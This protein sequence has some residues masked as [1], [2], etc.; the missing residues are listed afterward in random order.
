MGELS[1][2]NLVA[3]IKARKAEPLWRLI[4]ALGIPSVG[5]ATAKELANSLGSMRT[6]SEAM[7]ELLS[8]V[9]DVGRDIAHSI[10]TFFRQPKNKEVLEKLLLAGVRPNDERGI[11]PQF[12]S[13]VSMA[14]ILVYCSI[15]DVGDKWANAIGDRFHLLR[16][17]VEAEEAEFLKIQLPRASAAIHG[18]REF[19][20]KKENRDRLL[21]L[22]TQLFEFGIHWTS[23]T[24]DVAQSTNRGVVW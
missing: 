10:E 5:E 8:F 14:G 7:E 4:N 22:E 2:A 1:A 17:V 21:A 11:S 3:E 18:I 24:I 23:R 12:A 9:Q 15:R 20:S 6:I 19:V 16:E 13:R